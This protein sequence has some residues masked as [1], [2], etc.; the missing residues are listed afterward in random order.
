MI[1]FLFYLGILLG[2]WLCICFAVC[3]FVA[4]MV[5]CDAINGLV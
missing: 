3:D 5:D 2:F 1:A 4:L